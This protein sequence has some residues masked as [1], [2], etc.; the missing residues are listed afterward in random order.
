MKEENN[1]MGEENKG[2][3]KMFGRNQEERV[4]LEDG[5]RVWESVGRLGKGIIIWRRMMKGGGDELGGNGA[6]GWRILVESL[7]IRDAVW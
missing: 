1:A 3:R 6:E 4:R 5:I 7:G 2:S